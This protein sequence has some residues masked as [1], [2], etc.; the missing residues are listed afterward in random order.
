[1]LRIGS[2]L[3]VVI[4]IFWFVLALLKVPGQ[5]RKRLANSIDAIKRSILDW[6]H[7]FRDLV[8]FL[9]LF[10]ATILILTG[11]LFYLILGQSLGGMALLL[12]VAV[13]PVFAISM[14][15]C[16]ITQAYTHRFDGDDWVLLKRWLET[17]KTAPEA[18]AFGF[19][20]KV[21]FW[22]LMFFATLLTSIILTMFPVFGTM[23]QEFLLN[24]HR[25]SAVGFFVSMLFFIYILIRRVSAKATDDRVS[26]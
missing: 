17:K 22:P 12:H 1:M 23:G 4:V 15:A 24:V 13:A 3:V 26:E 20:Q 10:C 14:V 19:L 2:L 18:K 11:F 8:F 16:L 5:A 6:R 7:H 9:A 21:L 25:F